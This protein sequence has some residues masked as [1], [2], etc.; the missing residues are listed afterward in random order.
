VYNLYYN[1]IISWLLSF[2]TLNSFCYLEQKG[3]GDPI[4]WGESP[5][6]IV[7]MKE[8]VGLPHDPNPSANL[9]SVVEGGN[10]L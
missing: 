8:G 9:V 3:T 5:S 4:V 10:S 6:L 2:R 1:L 7:F